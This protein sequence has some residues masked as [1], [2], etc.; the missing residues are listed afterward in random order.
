M[1]LSQ[2]AVSAYKELLSNPQNNNL[3]IKPI[4][5]VI[6]KSETVTAQHNL[7]NDFA[8]YLKSNLPNADLPKVIFYILL[9]EIFGN[10]TGKDETGA[11][12]YHLKVN[13][14]V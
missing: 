3:P 5:E 7:F 10:C 12:G 4:T 8:L 14:V 11:A 9:Q 2:E 13:Q 6:V 1:I